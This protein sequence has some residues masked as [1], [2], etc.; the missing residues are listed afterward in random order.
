MK[1]PRYYISYQGAHETL[2]RIC[3]CYVILYLKYIHGSCE[4]IAFLRIMRTID[5]RSHNSAEGSHFSQNSLAMFSV[6]QELL[7]YVFTDAFNHLAYLGPANRVVLKDMV[8]LQSDIERYPAV[9]EKIRRM[10]LRY[11]LPV[12]WP[13]SQHDF[14]LYVLT[15]FASDSLLHAFL[16]P[17]RR[18]MKP[19]YRT[20]PLVYA[21]HF[22]KPQHAHLL[23]SRGAKVNER[24][25]VIDTSRQELPLE[26]AISRQHDAMVDLLLS[27]GSVVPQ[28][29]FHLTTNHNFPIRITRRL[30][31]TD[32]FMEWA[33][34]PG[35]KLPSPLGLLERRP[36]LVYQR[37]I[38]V[39]I[40]R[41]VQVGLDPAAGNSAQKT[42]LHLTITGGYEAVLVYLLLLGTPV[43]GDLTSTISRM[44]PSERASIVRLIVYT[45]VDVLVCGTGDTTLH[46]VV[47]FLEQDEC[48]EATKVLVGAGCKPF[49]YNQA[50]KTPLHLALEQRYYSVA[51]YLLSLQRP[52]SPDALSA[53]VESGCPMTRIIRIIRTLMDGGANIHGVTTYGDGLLHRAVMLYDERQGLEMAKFLLDAGCDPFRHNANDETPLQITFIRK[54]PLLA[55]CL[56]STGRPLP[57]GTLFTIL[58]SDLPVAWKVLTIR[59]LVANGADVCGLSAD[60]STLLHATVLA[61]DES[62]G[63]DVTKL[64]LSAGCD[65]FRRTV[66]GKTPFHMALDHNFPLIAEYLLLAKKPLPP[67]A[68]FAILRSALPAYWRVQTICSLVGQGVTASELSSDGSTLLH[69]SV[70]SLDEGQTMEVAKLL[71]NAG[72]EPFRRNVRRK[73]SFDLALDR[74][75]SF[76]AD[77]LLSTVALPPPDT[78]FAI[79]CSGLPAVWRA[80]TVSFLVGKGVDTRALSANGNTLLHAAVLAL[81]ESQAM[82]MAKLLVAAGCD[83][84]KRNVQGN[85]AFDLVLDR[86]SSLL[87]DYLLST[88]KPIPSDALFSILRSAL[89]TAWRAHIIC[90][91]IEQGAHASRLSTDGSTLL[92]A[93]ALCLD[94][95]HGLEV[96]KLL[97]GNGCNPFE[98]DIRGRTPL[99]IALDR[100]L[101]LLADYLA[102]ST[103]RSPPPD[104]LF[105]ILCSELPAAWKVRT[106][107]SHI[108]NGTSECRP[109]PDRH[110]LL[111]II[112][113]SLDEN[114]ALEVAKLL[115]GAGYD[116]FKR[117]TQA[118]TLLDLALAIESLPLADLLLSTGG[119]PPSDSL[120]AILRSA[121]PAHWKAR[122]VCSLVDKG[123]DV[124]GLSADGNTLLHIAVLSLDEPDDHDGH[125]ETDAC[126]V[127]EA[128]VGAGCDPTA[129]NRQG[130]TA[131]HIAA[132]CLSIHVTDYLLSLDHSLLPDD[133][134]FSALKS[135]HWNQADMLRLLISKGSNTHVVMADGNNLLHVAIA[136]LSSNPSTNEIVNMRVVVKI[137]VESGSNA[138]ARNARGKTPLHLA[139]ARGYVLIVDYLLLIQLPYNIT[140]PADIL[141]CAL[142]EEIAD[143]MLRNT[144]ATLLLLIDKRA[145]IADGGT[146]LHTAINNVRWLQIPPPRSPSTVSSPSTCTGINDEPFL[147]EV[148][149]EDTDV[150]I[151]SPTDTLFEYQADLS[152]LRII[153]LLVH[154]GCDP[155]QCDADGR[156]PVY[157]AVLRG[158]VNIVKYL[159]PRTVPQ[160]P[161]L[162]DAIELAPEEVQGEL[163]Q[164]FGV[165]E[166]ALEELD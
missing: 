158:F 89:P 118:G 64:L 112:M 68:L 56:L 41:L 93:T 116:P 156:P 83:P 22:G 132:E 102:L 48:M 108:S 148:P 103:G 141:A 3:L 7:G 121:L 98:Y 74:N 55:D 111:H 94:D 28:R 70:L 104:V 53:V 51:D 110:T 142:S 50:R 15:A 16:G 37:D 9:W 36:P 101:A 124:H 71:V 47:R 29:L 17:V 122:T 91:L 146:L 163:R 77:F 60:G 39:M 35:N 166:C 139:V 165:Q 90:S 38:I 125:Y 23:L 25:L 44:A 130:K 43:P 154:S 30:L 62:H 67:G 95:H 54:S 57:P 134:L 1:L 149:E 106:V 59:S 138:F 26:V 69:A 113:L 14:M 4:N 86:K 161:D 157:F 19:K 52:A 115:V 96:A 129:R 109:L 99:H 135:Y 2:A 5:D 105:A 87:A 120:F 131:L 34:E 147:S 11:K 107:S 58:R 66:D 46:L 144:R 114:Q 72:C 10:S 88:A 133:I 32:E 40:R 75:F 33:V 63:L 159:L 150:G 20:N 81:Y 78:L 136:S 153:E 123:A 151:Q 42:A 164:V 45:G 80:Q 79:L 128:L 162:Q 76:L 65:V 24:G 137:L 117:Y 6:S 127:A 119:P 13:A 145:N 152:L 97:V 100:N 21:A 126:R 27:T 18:T 143:T 61:F 82:D 155:S 31:Q 73:T 12:P 92:H 49:E 140:L 8:T 84:Y 85:S 160:P